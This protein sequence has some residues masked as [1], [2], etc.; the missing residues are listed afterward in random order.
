M[1][2]LLP[3]LAMMIKYNIEDRRSDYS[4]AV[5]KVKGQVELSAREHDHLFESTRHLLITLAEIEKASMGD[6]LS[7]PVLAGLMKEYPYISNIFITASDGRPVSSALP[8][9]GST[10]FSDREWFRRVMK[11]REF[12]V[13]GYIIG[14]ISG[15]PVVLLSY[16]VIG[17]RGNVEKV[18]GA[19][20]DLSW[21]KQFAANAP[22]SEGSTFKVID[23][24]G[25]VLSRY[26]DKG[27]LTGQKMPEA[28]LIKTILDKKTY[29]T[30]EV[31]GLD[32]VMRLYAYA[33][34]SKMP[35]V[36][37]WICIGIPA[38]TI[39]AEAEKEF[40]V[41][42]VILCA[43]TLVTFSAAWLF[44]GIVILRP[45]KRILDTTKCIGD[46]DLTARAGPP[47]GKG[48][49]GRLGG[50]FD[51]MADLLQA[52]ETERNRAEEEIKRMNLELEERVL[53]RTAELSAVNVKLEQE[54]E[55][56]VNTEESLRNALD[57][58]AM[59]SSE[60]LWSSDS[61]K[62]QSDAASKAKSEF[63]ANMSHELRTPLNSILGFSEVLMDRMF[64]DLND[65]QSI[66]V[67][68]IYKSGRHLLSLINDILD[69]SKVE[70]GKMELDPGRVYLKQT[71]EAS[72]TML[73]EKAVK[74]GI[75]LCVEMKPDAD[76]EIT[77]DE[78]KF[79]QI[80]Y[81]L[82]SNAVK[83]TPDGGRVCVTACRSDGVSAYRRDGVSACGSDGETARRVNS[84]QCIVNGEKG[85]FTD[86]YLL[87]TDG[88]FI[89]ISVVD[90]GIGIKEEDIPRLFKEFSQLESA[91]KKSY[92][93]TGLGLALA[94]RLVELHGGRIWV[95]SEFGKGSRFVFVIP[96]R[97][98]F[99]TET[100]RTQRGNG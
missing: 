56:R 49:I 92:E 40:I 36:G 66:Y 20:I 35:E 2:A 85:L 22:L 30:V 34:L 47:Y 10:N 23:K 15:K 8:F 51:R 28:M 41:N 29:G 26:P 53:N 71:L 31:P 3:T 91:Y 77:A 33:P 82:L 4:N 87:T 61:D 94:R 86:D 38:V 54:I 89:E 84:E 64:G 5:E 74:H 55:L 70:S 1:I 18:V 19:G 65:K 25:T 90:T 88:N 67:N 12:T 27:G 48:E 68:N 46:G 9:A 95:E 50:Y 24:E 43:I 21:M 42:T 58:L 32:N 93:G 79:K 7:S 16:P 17:A 59:R 62:I 96:V 14:R 60:M 63:L 37:A 45:M 44:G 83:F 13:G 39:Y 98:E 52:R 73:R 6:S 97:Q 78:R 99:T 57:E 76:I 75:S 100:Q 81:N 80:M 11:T 72:V 69:L